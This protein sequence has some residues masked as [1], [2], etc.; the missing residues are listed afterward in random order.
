M[1]LL[2][3]FSPNQTVHSSLTNSK[4]SMTPADHTIDPTVSFLVGLSDYVGYDTVYVALRYIGTS[5]DNWFVDD[6]H[7]YAPVAHGI[8]ALDAWYATQGNDAAVIRAH[9]WWPAIDD[10][11]YQANIE[12]SDFLLA[13]TPAVVTVVPT[14]YLDN[15][16]DTRDMDCV[17]WVE[18]IPLVYGIRSATASPLVIEV[19]YD[20]DGGQMQAIVEVIDPIPDGNYRL[21][22]AVTEDGV[23]AQGPN[24]EPIHNQ[25]FRYLYP[26][27]DGIPVDPVQGVQEFWVQ[28]D[29]DPEWVFDNLRGTAYV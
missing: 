29:L 9:V 19:G 2:A 11:I 5:A 7:I 25:A 16:L 4:F 24:G 14:L 23:E 13:M 6:V 17:L 12:Q 18:C 27:I 26:D 3:G 15:V 22:V 8:E 1:P 21:F 28:L 10:P 20:S